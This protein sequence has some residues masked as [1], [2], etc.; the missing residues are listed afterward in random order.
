MFKQKNISLE[1]ILDDFSGIMYG[2]PEESIGCKLKGKLVLKNQKPI[3]PKH[4]I[5][6]PPGTYEYEFDF[7][8]PGYLPSSFKGARG[9][10]EYSCNAILALPLFHSNI[11]VKKPVTLKRCL[12]NEEIP[13]SNQSNFNEG[14][15]D[16]RI[17]FQ[18]STPI[19]AYREG[20]LVSANLNLKPL[21]S[22]TFFESIE[23]G[24]KEQI[25][26]HT[27]ESYAKTFIASVKEDK[28][29]LG[30]KTILLD[31]F[32]HNSS[33]PISIDFRLCPWV[34]YS[35]PN[36]STHISRRFS[37]PAGPPPVERRRSLRA[38]SLLPSSNSRTFSIS[39]YL[40]QS[41]TERNTRNTRNESKPN[42]KSLNI[43]IPIIITTKPHTPRQQ[44][45]SY[46]SVDEPPAY[47]YASMIPPP[48][49]YCAGYSES[50]DENFISC[51]LNSEMIVKTS[52][53]FKYEKPLSPHLAVDKSLVPKDDDVLLA[54]KSHITECAIDASHGGG[55]LFLETAGVTSPIIPLRL[56][57]ILIGDSNLGGISTTISSF[58]SLR[59]HDFNN[60]LESLENWHNARFNRLN[61]MA[62]RSKEVV[63]WPFTQH[64]KVDKVNVIDSAY[65]DFMIIYDKEGDKNS[66]NDGNMKEMFDAS[67]SWWTQGLGHGSSKLSLSA[68]YAAGRY[69]HVLFPECI[70]EPSLSLSQ[71]LLNTI[72]NNWATRV[73]FSD[74]G[75]TAVEVALKMALHSTWK[76]YFNDQDDDFQKIKIL[77]LHG[78]YHGDTI[79]AMDACY[80]NP[81][82]K[83][84]SWYEPRGKWFHPPRIL[85]KNNV[86]NLHIPF[87]NQIIH[88]PSLSSI[89]SSERSIS[90]PVSLIYKNHIKET[91]TRYIKE[92]NKFGALIFEPIV[93]GA[94]GMIFVD[95]LFQKLL[96]EFVREWDGWIENWGDNMKNEKNDNN[97]W[98]GLPIIYDEVFTGFWRLGQLSG[99]KALGVT[100]DIA[101]YAKLLTGGLIPLA[102]TLTS[103]SIF[104]TF[105]GKSKLNSLLH[106][107]SYTA[108][109][110][111]CMVANT[112]LEEYENLNKT[113]ND[114][115]IG[116]ENWN[117]NE[118]NQFWS[119]WSKEV[120]GKIS[121][122]ENVEG[123]FALGSLLAIELKDVHKSG[124]SSDVSSTIINQLSSDSDDISILARPLGNVIYFMTSMISNIESIRKMEEKIL[125]CLNKNL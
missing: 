39:S 52:T 23:Y 75:S 59:L 82:N 94:G 88:Y 8:I 103:S 34:N 38:R 57:T 60:I 71:T 45:P 6:I 55:T 33:D 10:I 12:I 16:D 123:V 56:P 105:L 79:G 80:P 19:M 54:T 87:S 70:H 7:D 29:P 119:M 116:R 124:Y 61:E 40:S 100:P 5:K 42:T 1:I 27:T 25:H 104:S 117:T 76:R 41:R 120:V 30:T 92:G 111:G 110:I 51:F 13:L 101:S 4:L 2:N 69:G 81:F 49:D 15:L 22:E 65:K 102:V 121:C 63:W 98:K 28:F 77:G 118:D 125:N 14:I 84:V 96:V 67:S 21:N 107:H 9:K 68:S 11:L 99:A 113:S 72:G 109:P 90:D 95:P 93:M 78:S 112:S 85:L 46:S 31:Q 48:P 37:S 32:F 58:E 73:F 47:I 115:K 43:E 83:A 74:N 66:K 44:A 35:H 106:G 17:Q 50:S 64:E 86:Y 62:E 108:H 36:D 122:M 91:I 53:L 114:W 3:S 20:G 26:Y 24:I 97:D 89:F 18:I